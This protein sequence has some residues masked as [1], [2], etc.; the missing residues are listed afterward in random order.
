MDRELT[1]CYRRQYSFVALLIYIV[2]GKIEY[3]TESS[4]NHYE[5][6]K[7]EICERLIYARLHVSCDHKENNNVSSTSH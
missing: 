1:N 7:Y 6:I 5:V 4:I 3:L 2:L